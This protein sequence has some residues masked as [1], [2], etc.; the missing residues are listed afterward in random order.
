MASRW[1]STSG[2]LRDSGARSLP[3]LLFV[4]VAVVV[5]YGDR[6]VLGGVEA[7]AIR[8]SILV[9]TTH[10]PLEGLAGVELQVRLHVVEEEAA[11]LGEEEA[12]LVLPAPLVVLLVEDEVQALDLQL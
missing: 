12:A 8:G 2:R 6:Y 5:V 9:L 10:A 11:R 4:G 1:W 3:S 7:K